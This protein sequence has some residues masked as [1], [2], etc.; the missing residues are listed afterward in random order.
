LIRALGS[1]SKPINHLCLDI[2][3]SIPVKCNTDKDRPFGI[4]SYVTNYRCLPM[5]A[6]VPGI[7]LIRALGSISKPINHFCLDIVQP[8][9]GKCNTDKDRPFDID[10]YVTMYRC[11]P[12]FQRC[13]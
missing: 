6:D 12:M 1:I 11:L 5:F 13:F 7:F 8:I 9:P 3:Q 4:D 2:V 10:I